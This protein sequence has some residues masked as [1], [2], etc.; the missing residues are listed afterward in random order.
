MRYEGTFFHFHFIAAEFQGMNLLFHL[1]PGYFLGQSSSPASLVFLQQLNLL[2]KPS[3]MHVNVSCGF[4]R[5]HTHAALCQTLLCTLIFLSFNAMSSISQF[6][7]LHQ[8]AQLV[9]LGY[10]LVLFYVC[11][12]MCMVST[13]VMQL[14]LNISLFFY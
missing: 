5:S 6:Q 9:P 1:R 10:F 8:K 2:T 13:S 12:C 7:I 3:L 4:I 11:A 14:Y